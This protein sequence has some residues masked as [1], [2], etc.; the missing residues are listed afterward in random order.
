MKEIR[1]FS[2][3]T[4]SNV[5]PGFDLIGFALEGP[6]DILRIR[7]NDTGELRI[8][9][10]THIQLPLDVDKNVATIAVKSM[11]NALQ[12]S[13]GFDLIFENKI[14]PGSGIG[15]SAASCTAAV[16]GINE[17]LE[18]P[19]S[20]EELID[21]ALAGEFIASKS[22]HADN[23][24]P[25]MLGGIILIRSYQPLDIIRLKAPEDLWCT[26][27]H[28]DIEIKTAESRKLIPDTISLKDSLRQSG[29]LAALIAGI[30]TQ[31]YDLIGRSLED[32]IAEPVRKRS[33]PGY[34]ELKKRIVGNGV[35]GMNISGSG[36]SVF[37]LLQ[38]EETIESTMSIMKEIF[39]K[40]GISART[41]CSKISEKG[42]RIIG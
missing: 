8:F 35:L 25:A 15:S 27:V 21:H 5:G 23:I 36:P 6:G 22:L 28:P 3:A 32:W 19:L 9:N 41:Y 20:E 10:E 12:I 37:A 42:T 16:Y 39:R 1:I 30:T 4:V 26:V 31:D 34:D 14:Y 38:N 40:R 24:A 18:K 17:L 33:I 2:P 13:Q 11:I 7:K 29:N